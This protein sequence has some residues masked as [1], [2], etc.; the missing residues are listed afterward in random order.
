[1]ALYPDVEPILS[2]VN[3]YR[4]L[5]VSDHFGRYGHVSNPEAPDEELR[6][7]TVS[8][9]FWTSEPPTGLEGTFAKVASSADLPPGIPR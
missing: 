7:V 5:K 3:P 8:Q 6:K 1:M 9:A 4:L 2:S